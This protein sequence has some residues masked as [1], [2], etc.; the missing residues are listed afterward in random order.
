MQRRHLGH[1]ISAEIEVRANGC[2]QE[3]ETGL[4]PASNRIMYCR[5]AL[6]VADTWVCLVLQ[7][8][9][10]APPLLVLR[11]CLVERRAT[12]HVLFVHLAPDANQCEHTRVLTLSS[13]VVQRYAALCIMQLKVGPT[14]NQ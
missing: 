5:V 14:A 7:Q 11:C 6:V 13:S 8:V 9:L 10:H 1:V 4:I 3:L 2:Q 12:I